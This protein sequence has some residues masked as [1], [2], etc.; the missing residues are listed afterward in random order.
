MENVPAGQ[1]WQVSLLSAAGVALNVP[2]RQAW[3]AD[4]VAAPGASPYVPG[5]QAEQLLGSTAPRL[6]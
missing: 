2:A 5:G 1:V 4:E 6:G 3:H